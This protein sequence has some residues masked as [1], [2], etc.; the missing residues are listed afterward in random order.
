MRESTVKSD[1][2]LAQP[3]RQRS[4]VSKR[5]WKT[6]A[7]FLA[8]LAAAYLLTVGYLYAGQES[9]IFAG[10][11]LQPD[12]QFRADLPFQ[13][14]TIQT[15]GAELNALHFKQ[16]NPRGLVFFLRGNGGNL[17]SWISGVDYYRRV[18][19]DMFI[20]DY[21]GS[22]KSTGEIESEEQLHADVRL[23]WDLATA[24]YEGKPVVLYGRSL[25]AALATRLATEVEPDLLVLVSP[26]QNMLSMAQERY[27]FVPSAIL[28]YPFQN[29]E[30]IGRVRSPI[31]LVHGDE[32]RFIPLAHSEALMQSASAQAELMVIEG[33]N[34]FNIHT[35]Q[36]YLDGLSAA[37]PD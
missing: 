4:K 20:F 16:A 22:G 7:R 30:L 26:F 24:Q 27:P 34:H 5:I 12:H 33:A 14:L 11:K 6:S 15:E 13:E 37:L 9:L 28:R 17:Q 29:D 2:R 35:H 10:D 23:A 31:L 25:G 18:N 1:T 21:R 32:D 19:Y 8:I 3:V 36:R